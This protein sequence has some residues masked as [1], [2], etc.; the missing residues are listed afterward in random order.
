MVNGFINFMINYIIERTFE[1]SLS[2]QNSN[3]NLCQSSIIKKKS[4]K[5]LNCGD[6]TNRSQESF[7]IHYLGN[8]FGTIIRLIF[9]YGLLNQLGV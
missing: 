9:S 5:L 8:Y 2:Q 6:G 4:V 3:A 7:L 1:N